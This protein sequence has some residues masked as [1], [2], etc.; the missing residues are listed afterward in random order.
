MSYTPFNA[1]LLAGLL[2]DMESAASFSVKAEIDTMIGIERALLEALADTGFLEQREATAILQKVETF[3]PEMR[4]LSAGAA[5]DGVVVPELVRQLRD[6][7]DDE[8]AK[9][10]HFG[11]TSQDIVDTSLILRLRDLVELHRQR[12]VSIIDELDG[13]ADRDG[14]NSLMGRTRMQDALPISVSDR[15]AIWKAPLSARVSE[16][17]KLKPGLFVL[18]FGGAVGTLEKYGDKASEIVGNLAARLGLGVPARCWHTDRTPI[19][20][21]CEWLSRV[22][23]SLGKFGQDVAL[24]A[25]NERSEIR[26]SEGGSSSAIPHKQNPVLAESLVTL[27]KFNAT[28]IAGMHHAMVHEQERSGS[29]WA[30]E[31]MLVPPMAVATGAALRNGLKLA[32][33]IEKI[34]TG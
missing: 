11:A 13:L 6:T 25:Q 27:A 29:A 7:A 5:R 19:V 26:V 17:E 3:E 33:S 15:I 30:L 32:R 12:L 18:Q 28:Q 2:G 31:W 24:M 20:G 21:Y 4:A 1:P 14:G 10:L 22:T 16:L 8:T 9:W 23:G 34:G